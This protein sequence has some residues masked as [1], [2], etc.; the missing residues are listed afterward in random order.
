MAKE[1]KIEGNF[2][3][4]FDN[5]TGADEIRFPA[6]GVMPK[7]DGNNVEFFQ[8][9]PTEIKLNINT[10]SYDATT[11]IDNRTGLVF[12]SLAD[13]K[14]FISDNT[15]FFFNEKSGVLNKDFL[16]EVQKGNVPGYSLID[17]FG[18]NPSVGTTISTITTT[19]NYPTPTAAVSLEF[20]SDN[21]NDTSAG[22]GARSV[23]L[24]GQDPNGDEQIE[25]F[26]TNGLTAVAIP[27]TW[28]RVYRLFV[29]T[30]G[31]YADS[32][33]SSHLGNLTVQVSGGGAVWARVLALTG[34]FGLGQSQIGVYTVPSGFTA[35]LLSS[36]YSIDT[37][38]TVDL[39][40]FK[41]EGILTVSA[42]FSA[43]RLQALYEGVTGAD[44]VPKLT[45]N[46]FP[47]N[48]DFG[49]MA[50]TSS[51]T[52]SVSVE[53]EVLLIDNNYL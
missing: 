46:K 41:R 48:T 31:T 2:L 26:A 40:L 5:G 23:T 17:K 39:Y 36:N 42:P 33:N 13:F 22:T 1:I 28:L 29:A 6:G 8:Y 12:P 11:I 24:V 47:E 32:I 30:S 50:A 43:M 49:Y 51:G 34:N 53:F 3:V 16:L 25:T 44:H 45:R 15:G 21:A 27:G 10:A 9:Q 7:Y 20:V 14:T 38:K 4:V 52:A 35:F 37:N 18:R 19:G